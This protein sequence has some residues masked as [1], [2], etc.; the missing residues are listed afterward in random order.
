ML[1]AISLADVL[2]I[3]TLKSIVRVNVWNQGCRNHCD[4][5]IKS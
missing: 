3:S 5:Y 1:P 2:G 4:Q